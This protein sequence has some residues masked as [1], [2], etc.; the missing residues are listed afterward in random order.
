MPTRSK[1][2]FTSIQRGR[3]GKS[4]S[5]TFNVYDIYSYGI[6]HGFDFAGSYQFTD[7]LSGYAKAH[8]QSKE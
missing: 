6:F 7:N 4:P 5:G 8:H 2:T 3:R 1:I